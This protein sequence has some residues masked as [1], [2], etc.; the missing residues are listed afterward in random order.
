MDLTIILK[1]DPLLHRTPT[2]NRIFGGVVVY[3][4][5]TSKRG[6]KRLNSFV[7]DILW[8]QIKKKEFG[9]KNEIFLAIIY[10]A[11][12]SS[13]WHNQLGGSDIFDE[14]STEIHTYAQHGSIILIGY[15]NAETSSETGSQSFATIEPS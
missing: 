14:L 13:P 15:F 3:I 10:I 2:P 7:S 11:P 4:K 6:I 1:I 9:L 5:S 8:I 12:Y